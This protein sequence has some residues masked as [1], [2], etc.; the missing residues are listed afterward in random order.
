ML[1]IAIYVWPIFVSNYTGGYYRGT[2]GAHRNPDLAV[3]GSRSWSAPLATAI[4]FLLLMVEDIRR[5]I[6]AAPAR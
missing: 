6:R 4:Q 1:L 2:T 3:H 5:A